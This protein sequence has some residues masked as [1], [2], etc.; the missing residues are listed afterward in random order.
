[1][2]TNVFVND[3]KIKI[4]D[5]FYIEKISKIKFTLLNKLSK[6]IC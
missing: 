5:K 4:I 2:L 1:M 6:D 3:L